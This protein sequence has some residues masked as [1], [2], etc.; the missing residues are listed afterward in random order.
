MSRACRC[1][2][3]RPFMLWPG[4]AGAIAALILTGVGCRQSE[5]TS[6]PPAVQ[7]AD[8]QSVE[9]DPAQSFTSKRTLPPLP[10]L[11]PRL[12]SAEGEAAQRQQLELAEAL[13]ALPAPKYLAEAGINQR[14]P[15]VDAPPGAVKDYIDARALLHEGRV[16]EARQMLRQVIQ[17]DPKAAQALRLLGQIYLRSAENELASVYFRQALRANADDAESLFQLGRIAMSDQQMDEATVCLHGALERLKPLSDPGLRYLVHYYLGKCLMQQGYSRAAIEQ[18]ELFM[19]VPQR[20]DRNTRYLRAVLLLGRHKQAIDLEIADAQLRLG[21]YAQARQRYEGLV[22]D[23]DINQTALLARRVYLALLLRQDQRVATLLREHA[24]FTRLDTVLLRLIDYCAEHVDDRPALL[25]QIEIAY[26]QHDRPEAL[27][28]LLG[29]WMPQ[30]KSNRFLAEHLDH[31][32]GHLKVYRRLVD[33]LWSADPT[34]ALSMTI[35][36]LNRHPEVSWDYLNVLLDQRD[37]RLAFPAR[38]Q[39]VPKALLESAGG[40]YCRAR[41]AQLVNDI[42][43]AQQ[44]YNAALDREPDFV[45]A[46]WGLIELEIASGQY[47]RAQQ[48]IHAAGDNNQPRLRLLQAI[49]YTQMKRWDDAVAALEAL[50]REDATNPD[51]HNRRGLIEMRRG[52]AGAAESAFRQALTVDPTDEA[53]YTGLFGIYEKMQPDARKFRLLLAQLRALLPDSRLTRMKIAHLHALRR[54][55]DR[56]EKMLHDILVEFPGNGP[57]MSELVDVMLKQ[58]RTDEALAFLKKRLDTQPNDTVALD[59]LREASRRAFEM[60]LFYKRYETYLLQLP[61]NFN[62]QVRLAGLYQQWHQSEKAV[63]VLRGL[64]EDPNAADGERRFQILVELMQA[65]QDCGAS[66]EALKTLDQALTVRGDMLSLHIFRATLLHALGKS[67]QAVDHLKQLRRRFPDDALRLKQSLALLYSEMNRVELALSEADAL[68]ADY[69]DQQAEMLYF[70][71]QILHRA[72]R[73]EQTEQVLL[74]GLEADPENIHA[75]ND[76]GYTWAE[77][78]EQLDRAE[79]MIRKAVRAEPSNSAYLDSLGWVY[80]KRGEFDKA[81]EWLTR[82][83]RLPEGDDPTVLDHLGDALWRAGK[84]DR[85]E[86]LWRIALRMLTRRAKSYTLPVYRTLN[87]S[88]VAKLAAVGDDREPPVAPIAVPQ[89]ALQPQAADR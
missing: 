37:R 30:T 88:L 8:V 16:I 3:I 22:D 2:S 21:R 82:A 67:E 38:L 11:G 7:P 61:T 74:K 24:D 28:V 83:A 36:R 15:E 29:R 69:P 60:D 40:R 73:P 23:P 50:S 4:A 13:G 1:H 35:R 39:T 47:T 18:Y 75:N 72:E 27:A 20:F 80:Y 46:R 84:K 59:L 56:A 48:M 52:N 33:R 62:R 45:A 89:P 76:L 78:G 51:Y 63:P 43:T 12:R 55:F 65:E 68:I 87:E 42:S 26:R 25:E 64:L 10:L 44:A 54:E 17:A 49:L 66:E 86:R 5:K 9:P 71:A 31:C 32:P 79:Q 41:A 6:T 85:A 34:A 58:E 14:D 57:A 81:V 53:A 70:K 77:R 19:H